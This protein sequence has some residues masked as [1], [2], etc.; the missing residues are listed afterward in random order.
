MLDA[1]VVSLIVAWSLSLIDLPF[2][3]YMP[4]IIPRV[5]A[6]RMDRINIVIK[7]T[8]FDFIY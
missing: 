3:R 5:N 7:S 8:L 2:G 6:R 4:I 1:I